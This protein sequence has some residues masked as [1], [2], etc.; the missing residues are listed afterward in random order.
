MTGAPHVTAPT[1]LAPKARTFLNETQDTPSDHLAQM[2]PLQRF[3]N[4]DEIS[5]L[6]PYLACEEAG[7]VTG[8]S[9]T[10]DEG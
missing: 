7:Y 2:R 3:A 8:V 5:G 9:L 4:P 1:V 10:V 6:I